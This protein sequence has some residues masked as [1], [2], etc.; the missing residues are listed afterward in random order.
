MRNQNNF[1]N[2]PIMLDSKPINTFYS[3]IP[4]TTGFVKSINRATQLAEV[5][6]ITGDVKSNVRIPGPSIDSIGNGHGRWQEVQEGQ[7][8]F[9]GFVMGVQ[10]SPY[11][12]NTY[13]YYAKQKEMENLK[14]FIARYPEIQENEM[15][16]FHESGYCIRYSNNQIIFQSQIK[17]EKV[18]IDMVSGLVAI[19]DSLTVGHGNYKAIKTP[20]MKEWM[21]LT[22][23]CLLSLKT[24]IEGVV[25]VPLDGGASI[26]TALVGAFNSQPPPPRPSDIDL[27]NA[28][29]G[30]PV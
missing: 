23:A 5:V 19:Q 17:E 21:D 18:T 26:K 12:L 25:T 9:I 13:P 16:D 6:T 1:S 11:I 27:T 22:Y 8:V 7:L 10:N 24:A 30:D 15:V 3:P 2:Q 20:S 14:I 28:G 29:F 4:G